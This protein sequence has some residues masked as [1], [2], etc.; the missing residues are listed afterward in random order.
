[1]KLNKLVALVA[2]AMIVSV[3]AV[4]PAAFA[5][6]HVALMPGTAVVSLSQT[7]TVEFEAFCNATCNITWILILSDSTVG[8]ID[9]TSGPIT[10]FTGTGTGSAHLIASDG[11]G[12][13]AVA[14]VTVQ[15]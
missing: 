15:N 7:P 2:M 5:T 14:T 11:Q 13:T 1:M 4:P 10:H 9:T 8:Y 6:V 12:H 3:L